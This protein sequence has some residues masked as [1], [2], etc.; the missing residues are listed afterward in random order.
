ML[1]RL[2]VAGYKSLD[3]VDVELDPLTVVFGSN[4]AGKSNLLDAIGLL[5]RMATSPNLDA[6]FTDHRGTPL[7]AFRFPEDG[8]QGLQR[9]ERATFR[10]TADVRLDDSVV[11]A[12]EAEIRRAREGLTEGTTSRR[13]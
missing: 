5:S 13:P 2:Q 1:H 8:L 7:E 11:E 4:A 12:V 6:A 10:L 3:G 9:Q